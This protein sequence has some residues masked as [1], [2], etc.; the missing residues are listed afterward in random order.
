MTYPNIQNLTDE[1]IAEILDSYPQTG[2]KAEADYW[3]AVKAEF[4]RRQEEKP[5]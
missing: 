5:N 3:E 1:Q 2:F 4:E